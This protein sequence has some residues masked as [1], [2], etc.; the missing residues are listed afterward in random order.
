MSQQN[1]LNLKNCLS[2]ARKHSQ[3][4]PADVVETMFECL[5]HMNQTRKIVL[6][7]YDDLQWAMERLAGESHE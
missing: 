4:H 1:Y 7:G 6:V 5:P 2:E 3:D